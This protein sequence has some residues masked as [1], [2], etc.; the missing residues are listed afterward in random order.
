M[1]F[2][3]DAHPR[4]ITGVLWL[5]E[6]KQNPEFGVGVFNLW[7]DS[8]NI[9]LVDAEAWL[10]PYID[11]TNSRKQLVTL[12]RDALTRGTVPNTDGQSLKG[13]RNLDT[14]ADKIVLKLMELLKRQAL[15]I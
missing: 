6:Q 5:Y 2:S 10:L 11:G 8:V 7:H 4:L 13:Q 1:E 14:V 9:R 3:K 15:L 12:L